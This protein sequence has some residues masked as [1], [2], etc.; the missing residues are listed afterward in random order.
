M[1]GSLFSAIDA[2]TMV[3]DWN[4]SVKWFTFCQKISLNTKF[5]LIIEYFLS[6]MN[7]I[8]GVD[9]ILSTKNG[10]FLINVF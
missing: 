4:M 1:I 6:F 3:I 8:K 5:L 7:F 2:I 9:R 10:K